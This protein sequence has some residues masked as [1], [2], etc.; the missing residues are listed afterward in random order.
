MP[1]PIEN[2]LQT[3]YLAL[4]CPVFFC[5]TDLIETLFSYFSVCVMLIIFFSLV[6]QVLQLRHHS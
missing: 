4:I 6:C 2:V 3:I 1:I 5:Q